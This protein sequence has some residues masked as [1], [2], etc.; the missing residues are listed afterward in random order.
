MRESK[1]ISPTDEA[2]HS[3]EA[4][5]L[6]RRVMELALER[7]KAHNGAIFL[8]DRKAKGLAIHFHLV[9]DLIINLPGVILRHRHDDRPNSLHCPLENRLVEAQP[10]PPFPSWPFWLGGFCW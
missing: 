2:L 4:E 10:P 8:W 6:E 9:D 3:A 1:L 5:S 7:T